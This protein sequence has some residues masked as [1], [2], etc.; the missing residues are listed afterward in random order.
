MCK[1]L[2]MV[3]TAHGQ[4]DCITFLLLLGI[5]CSRVH[6]WAMYRT[7]N[8]TDGMGI[9]MGIFSLPETLS[10]KHCCQKVVV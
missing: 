6:S 4:M 5:G 3:R 10:W 7:S 2:A 9:G 8:A 1:H